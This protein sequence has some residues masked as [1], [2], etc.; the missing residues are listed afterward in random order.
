MTVAVR[1]VRHFGARGF[2]PIVDDGG[3]AAT[4]SVINWR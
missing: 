4:T 1:I 3:R 2:D